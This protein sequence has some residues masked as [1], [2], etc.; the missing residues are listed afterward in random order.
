MNIVKVIIKK[1]FIEWLASRTREQIDGTPG[2]NPDEMIKAIEEVN[3]MDWSDIGY[4]CSALGE[5]TT[6]GAKVHDVWNDRMW[7]AGEHA[8]LYSNPGFMEG[9]LSSG[10]RVAKAIKDKDNADNTEKMCLARE[11]VSTGDVVFDG[12]VHGHPRLHV[13]VQAGEQNGNG[14]YGKGKIVNKT[15]GKHLKITGVNHW[16]W[17]GKNVYLWPT[18][19]PED[20]NDEVLRDFK[21][22]LPPGTPFKISIEIQTFK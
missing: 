20:Y 3:F 22:L 12:I 17:D 2:L 14:T 21:D 15:T 18:Y 1:L 19:Y 13:P 4:S 6:I 7:I 5:I 16:N 10:R 8:C 9:A 11:Y